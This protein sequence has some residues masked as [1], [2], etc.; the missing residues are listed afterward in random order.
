MEG[1]RRQRRPKVRKGRKSEESILTR[2]LGCE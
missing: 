1:V 2:N